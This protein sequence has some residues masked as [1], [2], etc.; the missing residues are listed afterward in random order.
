MMNTSMGKS[1]GLKSG[2]DLPTSRGGGGGTKLTGI[3][4]PPPFSFFASFLP[5]PSILDDV[6]SIAAEERDSVDL[7]GDGVGEGGGGGGEGVG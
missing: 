7:V 6:T 2:D 1:G 4:N 5:L 3:S